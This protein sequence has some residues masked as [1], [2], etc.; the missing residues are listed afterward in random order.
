MADHTRFLFI[1]N[2]GWETRLGQI[3]PYDISQ[4]PRQQQ[5]RHG[6]GEKPFFGTETPM[7][8]LTSSGLVQH[9]SEQAP[10][11]ATA[12]FLLGNITRSDNLV[13]L[14]ALPNTSSISGDPAN[15]LPPSYREPI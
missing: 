8:T 4:P 3:S 7:A 12:S 13:S 15:G 10:A 11:V 5:P 2:P 1:I 9:S 6:G 14:G